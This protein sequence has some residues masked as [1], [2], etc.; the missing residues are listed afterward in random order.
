MDEKAKSVMWESHTYFMG[1]DW[2]TKHHAVVILDREGP[3][4]QLGLSHKSK[5]FQIIRGT[6]ISDIVSD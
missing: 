2:A 3:P 1:F 6:K 4:E 5:R